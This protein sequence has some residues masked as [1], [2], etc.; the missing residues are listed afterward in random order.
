LPEPN[1]AP[2][3]L[4]T[5]R[6]KQHIFT[7]ITKKRKKG[8]G[9]IINTWSKIIQ[10]V[11]GSIISNKTRINKGIYLYLGEGEKKGRKTTNIQQYEQRHKP[12]GD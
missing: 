1:G 8:V 9:D 11:K 5:R 12:R 7:G 2:K 4:G 6:P 10:N 3:K